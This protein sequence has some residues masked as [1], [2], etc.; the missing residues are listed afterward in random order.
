MKRIRPLGYAFGHGGRGLKAAE[1]DLDSNALGGHRS[2][3]GGGGRGS[4]SGRRSG[5]AVR[6][7]G[8]R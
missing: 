5:G 2:D 6:R 8:H 3:N 7:F 1:G 4:G